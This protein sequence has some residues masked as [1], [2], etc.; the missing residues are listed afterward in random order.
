[1]PRILM[2]AQRYKPYIGG[3]EKHIEMISDTLV[4]SGCEISV[5][6]PR[7]D[8]K[9]PE[10]ERIGA[11]EII[12]F[13]KGI[14]RNPLKLLRWFI[15]KKKMLSKFQIIHCHDF[16]PILFWATPFRLVLPSRPIFAT[17]HGY[18]DD[19]VPAHFK[20]IRKVAERLVRN[21]LCIGSFIEGVYGTNC[22]AT[23]IGAVAQSK[24]KASGKHHAIYVGRLEPDTA[25]LGYIDAI[26]STADVYGLELKLTVCGDGSLRKELEQ[27]CL[28][29][30]ISAKFLGGIPDPT[31]YYL[32]ADVALA[33][34]FLSILEAMSYGLPV[35]AHSGTTLKNQYY[36]SV[37]IL[38]GNI[39]IQTTA[40]GVAIE[41]SRLLNSKTLYNQLSK[42]AA[43]FA[44]K[45]NW[46]RLA[47]LYLKLW[48]SSV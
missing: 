30:G 37:R 5:L 27:V 40:S 21:S 41:I 9:L 7:F 32:T 28:D 12:R 45:N 26:A 43:E 36:K 10:I 34:G 15:S 25:I 33:G 38:G 29:K 46:I 39:S 48:S 1:M 17:F 35:I 19:P 44:E 23:P 22:F 24:R 13:P 31:P 14:E 2:M 11:T 16:I 47:D 18:E 20:Y 4:D 6:T 8:H 42:Q 3:V